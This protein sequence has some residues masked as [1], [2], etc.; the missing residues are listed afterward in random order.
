MLGD[1]VSIGPGAT[2]AG[3]IHVGAGSIVGAGAVVLPN[4]RIGEGSIVSAGAVVR[5]HVAD[6]TLV[7][8]NP[9]VPHR[10]NP[11]RSSLAVEDGE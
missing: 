2:L 1:F 3:N 9:A 11:Q 5:K 8:G 10:F 4:V 7:L 6:S